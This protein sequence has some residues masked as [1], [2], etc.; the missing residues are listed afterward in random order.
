ML[1]SLYN[2]FIAIDLVNYIRSTVNECMHTAHVT[3]NSPPDFI[4]SRVYTAL[5]FK[6][7][8]AV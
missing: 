5:S 8:H 6:Q 3:L 7:K 2:I 1:V 4:R